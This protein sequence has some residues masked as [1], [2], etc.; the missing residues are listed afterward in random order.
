MEKCIKSLLSQTMK[1]CE[2]IFVNDGSK[3]NS[4]R[5]L[6]SYC[7]KDPRIKLFNQRNS[8]VSEARNRG[9]KIAR[10]EYIGFVDS[11]DYVKEDFIETLYSHAKK[12]DCELI[13]SNY[14][15]E[16]DG[17]RTITT[18]N[19][20]KN[21]VMIGDMIGQYMMPEMVKTDKFNSVCNKLFKR[22]VITEHHIR[23]PK[24]M[25]LGEDA[26]FNMLVLS[27]INIL[28]FIDYSGYI[29]TEREGSAT[30]NVLVHDY[31]QNAIEKF[32]EPLPDK[33]VQLLGEDEIHKMKSYKLI[34]AVMTNIYIYATSQL[35]FRE[36]YQY[37]QKMIK[38][39]T[40]KLALEGYEKYNETLGRYEQFLLQMIRKKSI[41]GLFL[42]TNYSQIRN[43]RNCL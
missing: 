2:F 19:N 24:Q 8:G 10:G 29:Y 39:P 31:F 32:R 41:L 37:L 25:A 42:A 6:E 22:Q 36:K 18:I 27:Q 28:S 1:D 38:H 30:R 7:D 20:H 16:R 4:R 23:F 26:M 21:K 9:L 34:K 14:E 33:F 5:I 35:S 11:D 15:T 40:V 17:K 43:R 12:M 13:V 3:D